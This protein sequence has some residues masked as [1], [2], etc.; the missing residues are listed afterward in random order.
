[1][2]CNIMNSHHLHIHTRVTEPATVGQGERD[3]CKASSCMDFGSY[4]ATKNSAQRSV[5]FLASEIIA[6]A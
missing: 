4:L 5:S 2:V 3:S 1:M 6:Y